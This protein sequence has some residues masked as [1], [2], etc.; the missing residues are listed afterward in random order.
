MILTII[1]LVLAAI[2]FVW[3]KIRADIV[4]LVALLV[5]TV[6]GVINTQE[7]LSGFSNPI[8]I[9]MVGL[10]IVG[11]AIFNTGL[12]K[13]LGGR[14]SRLGGG[15]AT[16][17][18]LV[19]VLVTGLIGGFVSN[20]GTVALM[21]PI[22]V[23]M[24]ASAGS[25]PSRFLMPL[26]FASS[27]GGMLT[28]IGTPPNL[29][30]AEVWEEY[31][32]E[33]LTMFTF[34]PGGIIC[35]V[36]GTLLLIPLSRLLDKKHGDKGS[37]TADSSQR[38]L[39]QIVEEYSLNRDLWR[40]DVP[41]DSPIAGL[42]LGALALRA[43]YGLDVLELRVVEGRG[44]LKNVTQ[45]APAA[46][47]VVDGGSVLFVRGP[48]DAVQRFVSD[49]GLYLA[50]DEDAVRKNLKFYDIGLA[51]IVPLPN[52]S[53]LKET[54]A[55]L[56]F[57]KRF[58]VN[59]LGVRRDGEYIIDN[60]GA[61]KVRK[62][63]VLL[64]QG[65]WKAIGEISAD[66]RNWVVLGQPESEASK[67]TIDYKAPLAGAIMLAMIA[68]LVVGKLPAVVVVLL[69]SVAMILSGCFRSVA[70][71]YRTINWESVV[72][73]AAM[74]PMS[75]ALEK[76]GVSE[77]VSSSLVNALGNFG[78]HM[79][80]AG[81][82]VTTSILTL[83][84]SNTATAVLMAPIAVQSAV[85]YGV[86]PLPMLFAVTFAA[87]LCFM[88]P[89]STPPNALVMPAGEYTF[90]DYIKVGGPLQL[91]LGV[92]MILVLPLIFPF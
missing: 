50:D 91:I 72:L 81:I 80:M 36:A 78:P 69:A 77:A 54:I 6:G 55:Q 8:V 10:F 45:E 2:G 66:T 90:M 84:I 18:F 83:F 57:R 44:L 48:E 3:G 20:T 43:N 40:I 1:T 22:V 75:F 74:M 92:L 16:R 32:G 9:M 4:A 67:V 65:T 53:I 13:M 38:S 56:D 30:I 46:S 51:E 87:S 88:S 29:V 64:V 12:A 15:N 34:L 63:D 42:S 17:L 58:N 85:A 28:L 24:T 76:T 73:I 47:T 41:A 68:A 89:F 62:A 71:A 37:Q 25:N 19:V 35:L 60:L 23:S 21:L 82:Y 79:L 7:A 49:Y 33:A 52:S 11:G 70:D 26:A 14:L 86:S 27:I 5:L 39:A 59:I 61:V 31:G